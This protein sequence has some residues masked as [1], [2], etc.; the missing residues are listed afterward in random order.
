MRIRLAIPDRLVTPEALEAALEATAL[1]NEQAVLH[2]EV[3]HAEEAIRKGVKWRPEPYT[4]GEH[5]DLAHQVISRGWGDCDDLAPYLAGSLRATGEDPGAVPRVY[6]SGKKTWHVVTQLSDGTVLDPSR[7]AGMK[8]R[9]ERGVSGHLASPFARVGGGAL[10]CGP[11][12][13]KWWARCDVPW[14]DATGHIASHARARTPEDALDRAVSGAMACGAMID[15][16]LVARADAARQFLLSGPDELVGFGFG[17]L[18]KGALKIA[19][20]FASFV[21][22]GSLATS[23]LSAITKGG[24]GKHPD[25]GMT[26]PSGAVSVP[27]EH[28]SA[29]HP[30]EHEQHMMLYYHPDRAPG[31]VIMR[32]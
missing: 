2:G 31:P 30:L 20:P 22:G 26:H 16:P 21:P 23:A 24:G 7:W 32:F 8:S 6:R 17:K 1:A 18:L 14:P 10:C 28:A 5:F 11:A 12:Q 4:D 13:G 27:L 19:K 3:P 25:G 29:E 15:S 9:G